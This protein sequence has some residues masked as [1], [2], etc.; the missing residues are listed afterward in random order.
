MDAIEFLTKDHD[1]LKAVL[2]A[3]NTYDEMKAAF[4]E[5]SRILETHTYLEERFFYPGFENHEHLRQLI[6]EAREQHDLVKQVLEGMKHQNG[7]EFERNFQTLRAE[8]QLHMTSEEAEIFPQA[9][10]STDH[11]TLAHLG[12]ELETA[13]M[14]FESGS[15]SS[16]AASPR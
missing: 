16:T 3:A 15:E 14:A 1:A 7:Q 9:E 13:K 12:S 6:Q 10:S 4:G 11:A 8:V 2:S 5:I